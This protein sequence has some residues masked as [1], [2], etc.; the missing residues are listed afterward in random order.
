MG[1]VGPFVVLSADVAEWATATGLWSQMDEF[2]AVTACS[3]AAG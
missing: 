3:I 1:G 2:L